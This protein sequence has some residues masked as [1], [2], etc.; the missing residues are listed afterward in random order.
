[1][2]HTRCCWYNIGKHSLGHNGP[3]GMGVNPPGSR[4]EAGT[5]APVFTAGR[6]L[7]P[8]RD[9]GSKWRH[10]REILDLLVVDSLLHSVCS[11]PIC[12]QD[13]SFYGTIGNKA[14]SEK[15]KTQG[16]D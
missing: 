8:Y 13:L 12:F 2:L 10:S 6:I 7:F 1:M 3:N 9:S 5:P 14:I 4:S 16:D 11:L 15:R